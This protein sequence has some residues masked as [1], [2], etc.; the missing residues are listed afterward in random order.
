MMPN[1]DNGQHWLDR[2]RPPRV[3]ITYDVEIGDAFEKKELPLV[4]GIL[5]DLGESKGE[6][7]ALAK[8]S[9]MAIDRDNFDL[10]LSD[11]APTV[12][13]TGSSSLEKTEE[14][15]PKPFTVNLTFQKMAD[16]DPINIVKSDETLNRLYVERQ[17]L[18]DMQ[19]R[20]DGN[21]TLEDKLTSAFKS[22]APP[23][24]A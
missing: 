1:I 3:Q 24:P 22:F 11:I 20:L 15:K 21:V 6:L 4:M 13:V 8:R 12:T 9:F 14:D 5:A 10:V 23:T 16:F 2:N 17:R 18:R 19:A 7:K